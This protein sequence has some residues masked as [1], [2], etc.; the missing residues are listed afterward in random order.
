[1]I[2]R[3]N[4]V[5]QEQIQSNIIEEVTPDMN[6]VDIVHYLS[7]HE[8]LTP[9]KLTTKLRIV[10]DASAYLKGMKS[11]NDVLYRTFDYTLRFGKRIASF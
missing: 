10:Y 2:N 5:I 6:Q 3:Y 8:L 1:M 9:S 7:H 11:L 4:E